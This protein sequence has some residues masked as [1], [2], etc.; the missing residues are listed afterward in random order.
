MP[1]TYP[2]GVSKALLVERGGRTLFL[3]LPDIVN[4]KCHFTPKSNLRR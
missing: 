2:E 1:E 3:F 4:L